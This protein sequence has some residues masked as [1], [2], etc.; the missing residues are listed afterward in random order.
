MNISSRRGLT[1]PTREGPTANWQSNSLDYG[2]FGPGI[3]LA[4]Q[5]HPDL[6]F[7]R[8]D[9]P[10]GIPGTI[11]TLVRRQDNSP[12]RTIATGRRRRP[13]GCYYSI[14]NGCGVPYESRPELYGLYH[15]EVRP[16]VVAYF[17]QPHT[18][19]IHTGSETLRMTPDLELHLS[20]GRVEVIEIK[21]VFDAHSDH[22]YTAKLEMVASLCARVGWSF[23][24]VE[25]KDLDAQPLFDAIE[26]IQSYRRTAITVS[27]V[28]L[29]SNLFMQADE[30]SLQDIRRAYPTAITGLAKACAM[31]VRRVIKIDYAGGLNE[32]SRVRIL[33][34][35]SPGRG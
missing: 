26:A 22:R 16:D 1:F 11:A 18:W 12:M 35:E 33:E 31:A 2:G 29:I 25:K 23:K 30:L 6:D 24:V 10:T 19:E 7:I 34:R 17:A 20:N 9:V 5:N 28:Q 4:S 13:V 3:G 14:K 15:A 21:D 32:H 8:V 27:D